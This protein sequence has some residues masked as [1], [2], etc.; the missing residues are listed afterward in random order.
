MPLAQKPHRPKPEVQLLRRRRISFEEAHDFLQQGLS[1]PSDG[2]S[3]GTEKSEV[4]EEA[5]LE[6]PGSYLVSYR[7]IPAIVDSLRDEWVKLPQKKRPKSCFVEVVGRLECHLH[8]CFLSQL[9]LGL[10]GAAG[11]LLHRYIET[12]GCIPLGFME[13]RPAGTMAALVA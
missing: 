8:P 2:S 4:N 6:V 13:L 9:A 10:R 3:K 7:S 5:F 1:S 11:F 12:L